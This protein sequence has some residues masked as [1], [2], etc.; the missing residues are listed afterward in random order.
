M[1]EDLT[2]EELVRYEGL[3]VIGFECSECPALDVCR[4]RWEGLED[5]LW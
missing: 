2:I 3:C 1:Y 4:S 5:E